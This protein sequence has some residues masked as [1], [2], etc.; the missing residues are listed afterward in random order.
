MKKFEFFIDCGCASVKK[1]LT[2]DEVKDYAMVSEDA[3]LTE[4][5]MDNALVA[6]HWDHIGLGWNEIRA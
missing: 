1:I 5:D 2:E 6:W 4:E 3:S